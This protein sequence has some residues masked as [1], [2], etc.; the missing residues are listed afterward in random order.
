MKLR[1]NHQG[2]TSIQFGDIGGVMIPMQAGL[3]QNIYSR[4][5]LKQIFM[6]ILICSMMLRL[7]IETISSMCYIGQITSVKSCHQ[8][9]KSKHLI[10]EKIQL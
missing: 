7:G 5:L 2:K 8:I 4:L 6:K 3:D 9:M 10:L 1:R